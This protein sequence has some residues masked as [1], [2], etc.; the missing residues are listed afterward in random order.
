MPEMYFQIR[1]PD[2]AE[3]N[4]YSPSLVI[5]DFLKPGES[6][7]LPDFVGRCDQALNEASERVQKKFGYFCSSAMDQLGRIH[8]RAR[9]FEDQ[10]DAVV[11]VQSF[12]PGSR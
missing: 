5:G 11:A 2:G 6:Y 7:P 3:E 8:E 9:Q 10:P 4:C 1:W 12:K